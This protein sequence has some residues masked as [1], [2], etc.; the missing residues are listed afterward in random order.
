MRNGPLIFERVITSLIGSDGLN[1]TQSA[2][3][4][5]AH[6]YASSLN[7]EQ[8]SFICIETQQKGNNE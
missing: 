4:G 2:L 8:P 5:I 1:F 7:R 6:E 3:Q